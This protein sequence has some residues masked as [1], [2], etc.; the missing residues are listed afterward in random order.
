[1]GDFEMMV[2]TVDDEGNVAFLID[3]HPMSVKVGEWILVTH[4]IGVQPPQDGEATSSAV[5]GVVGDA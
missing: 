4:T 3:G 5:P 1:M 2:T